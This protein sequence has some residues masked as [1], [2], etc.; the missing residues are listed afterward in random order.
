M[1]LTLVKT[2]VPKQSTAPDLA[3]SLTYEMTGV[4]TLM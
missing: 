2:Y 4:D 3:I 1:R